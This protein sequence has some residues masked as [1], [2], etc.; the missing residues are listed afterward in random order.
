VTVAALAVALERVPVAQK[1][2]RPGVATQP[3]ALEIP[4][5]LALAPT[6][7]EIFYFLA[8][9]IDIRQRVSDI[10]CAPNH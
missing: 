1:A 9:V 8:D 2:P 7:A 5:V 10:G 4:G 6:P 3:Q